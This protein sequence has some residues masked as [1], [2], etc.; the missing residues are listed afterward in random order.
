M[1]TYMVFVES[2]NGWYAIPS[3]PELEEAIAGNK[4][5]RDEAERQ[6]KKILLSLCSCPVINWGKVIP[7]E[8]FCSARAR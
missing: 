3:F 8:R 4:E 7:I 5:M 1:S 6:I 2:E